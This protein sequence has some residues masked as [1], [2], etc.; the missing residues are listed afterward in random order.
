MKLIYSN[1]DIVKLYDIYWTC[2]KKEDSRGYYMIYDFSTGKIDFAYY[3]YIEG[4]ILLI[5][6][7]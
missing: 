1:R 2:T 7:F 5:H 3:E 6:R 4:I